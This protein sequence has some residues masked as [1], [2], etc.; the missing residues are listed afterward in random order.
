MKHKIDETKLNINIYQAL[1]LHNSNS[2]CS[3]P[4][5]IKKPIARIEEQK[6]FSLRYYNESCW[7][8]LSCK[9]ESERIRTKAT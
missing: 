3:K 7:Q 5:L 6:V 2:N 4:Y 8:C 9:W 1:R